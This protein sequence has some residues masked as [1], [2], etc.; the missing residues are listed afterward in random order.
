MQSSSTVLSPKYPSPTHFKMGTQDMKKPGSPDVIESES[1]VRPVPDSTTSLDQL[2]HLAPEMGTD[3]SMFRTVP[4]LSQEAW[5]FDILSLACAAT[6]L[7]AIIILLSRYDKKPNPLWS[8][9]ITLNTV[10]SFA[11]MIFRVGILVPV[12]NS[13]SQ[14]CWIW[15]SEQR[16]PLKHIILFDQ[17]SR[18][19][20]GGLHALYG[21]I[22]RYTLSLYCL[23]SV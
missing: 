19:P 23:I 9:G 21:G 5:L 3:D 1:P 7:V 8:S 16:R 13:I 4:F 17:A 2:V 15:C 20:L 22:R 6:V 10:L 14:L 12:V 18:G 11:S